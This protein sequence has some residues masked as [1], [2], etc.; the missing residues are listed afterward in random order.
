MGAKR[1]LRANLTPEAYEAWHWF[2]AVNGTT[3]SAMLEGMGLTFVEWQ[4][5]GAIPDTVEG[6]TEW[7]AIREQARIVTA[8]RRRG[9]PSS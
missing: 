3:L 8:R 2:A 4:R 9:A 1:S 7:I 5:I 6:F